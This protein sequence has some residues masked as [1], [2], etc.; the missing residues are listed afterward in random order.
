MEKLI[1]KICSR[2]YVVEILLTLM[3]NINQAIILYTFIYS[4]GYSGEAH[5][6]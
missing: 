2:H 5:L 6:F 1:Y 4:W 3:F